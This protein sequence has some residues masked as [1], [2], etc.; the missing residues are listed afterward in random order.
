MSYSGDFPIKCYVTKGLILGTRPARATKP[1][2]FIAGD[3]AA[4]AAFLN[5]GDVSTSQRVATAA[6][7]GF[8]CFNWDLYGVYMVFIWCLYGI[9]MGFSGIYMVFIWC[10]YGVYMVFSGIYMVFIWCLYGI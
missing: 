3:G 1:L 10:L 6:P 5:G 7:M 4:Q 9:Y 2:D 8:L